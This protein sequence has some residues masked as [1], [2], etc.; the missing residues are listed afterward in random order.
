MD[1]GFASNAFLHAVPDTGTVFLA[2]LSAAR[3]PPVLHRFGDGSFLSRLGDIEVSIIECEITIA[4][5]AGRHTGV[6]RRVTTILDARRYPA[7][8]LVRLYHERWEVESAYFAIKKSML[9]R[10]VLRAR[11][12]PGIAQ[13]ICALL[14]VYQVVIRIAIADATDSVSRADPDRTR[15]SVALHAARDQVI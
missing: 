7:F 13:E 1:R 6:Y 2:R 15:F 4:T 8:E 14:T 11:T 10:R 5:T 12:L 9:G 3:R